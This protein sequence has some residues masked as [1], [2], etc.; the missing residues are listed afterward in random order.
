MS[1]RFCNCLKIMTHLNIVSMESSILLSESR[2]KL[3]P[4]RPIELYSTSL[5]TIRAEVCT[6]K[7]QINEAFKL[8]V[9]I[10]LIYLKTNHMHSW[11]SDRYS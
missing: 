8:F 1:S 9:V 3:L 10:S 4:P 7:N 5:K 11:I 6:D 2:L